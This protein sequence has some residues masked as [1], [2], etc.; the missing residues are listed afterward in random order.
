MLGNW[1]QTRSMTVKTS[2]ALSAT[3]SGASGS[4]P[5]ERAISVES[6]SMGYLTREGERA[7]RIKRRERHEMDFEP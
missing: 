4:L 5:D 2:R 1:G 3:M 7:G 6:R